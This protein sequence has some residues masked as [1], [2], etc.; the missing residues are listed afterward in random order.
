MEIGD[1]VK[2]AGG[3]HPRL[4]GIVVKTRHF[5]GY[6]REHKVIWETHTLGSLKADPDGSWQREHNLR[7]VSRLEKN[8]ENR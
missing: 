2:W 3:S 8:D 5:G 1:Y 4:R 6:G 7:I